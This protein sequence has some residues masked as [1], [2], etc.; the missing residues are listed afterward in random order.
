MIIFVIKN[1]KIHLKMCET[2]I[3]KYFFLFYTTLHCQIG[4]GYGSGENFLDPARTKKVRIRNPDRKC[5]LSK[6]HIQGSASSI[7]EV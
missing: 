7:S 6:Y 4:S 3:L 2:S 1:G 5:S